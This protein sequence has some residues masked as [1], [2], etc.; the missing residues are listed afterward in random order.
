MEDILDV[1]T[2]K[3]DKNCP[4]VCVDEFS[5]QLI[6]EVRTPIPAE[7]GKPERFDTEYKRNE[8]VEFISF[9]GFIKS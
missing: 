3:H 1:Y 8:A 5:R 7:P 9:G 4:L 6:G 2:R